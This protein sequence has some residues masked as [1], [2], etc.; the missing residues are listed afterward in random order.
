[1]LDSLFSYSLLSSFATDSAKH[2]FHEKTDVIAI[3]LY[4][5][6]EVSSMIVEVIRTNFRL[7]LFFLQ[8]N[9]TC[10]KSIKSKKKHKKHTQANK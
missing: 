4:L 2:V 10:I 8:E 1:M 5:N 3:F 6:M 7:L 9:F